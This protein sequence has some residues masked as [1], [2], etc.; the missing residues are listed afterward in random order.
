MAGAGAPGSLQRRSCHAAFAVGA[1]RRSRLGRRR[2]R[3]AADFRGGLSAGI[4]LGHDFIGLQLELG[5]GHWAAFASA[6]P[7][8]FSSLALGGRWSARP[9]G[10]G[11]GLA[12]QAAV[13]QTT[14]GSSP[15]TDSR[16]TVTSVAATAHWRWSFVLFDLGAGPAVSF[17]SY[18]FPTY[19]DD[20][21]LADDHKLIR[22]TCVGLLVDVATCGFPLDIELGLGAAF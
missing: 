15:Y 3:R 7:L 21:N 6:G 20:S 19:A 22:V 13:F 14:G 12:L 9:D 11:F 5:A 18:R 10:S 8:K 2:Q 16:E 17:D 4:G 1:S